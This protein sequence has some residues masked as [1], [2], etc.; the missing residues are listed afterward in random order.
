MS[1]SI[2]D[3]DFENRFETAATV[4]D[5]VVVSPSFRRIGMETEYVKGVFFFTTDLY[6]NYTIDGLLSDDVG[7]GRT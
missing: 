4:I 3:K 6:M 7:T 1:Y 2:C 5:Y